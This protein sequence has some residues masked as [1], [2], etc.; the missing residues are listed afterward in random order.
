MVLYCHHWV[1]DCDH[2]VSPLPIGHVPVN[3]VWIRN[4]SYD[5]AQGP[6]LVLAGCSVPCTSPKTCFLVFFSPFLTRYT[7][8]PAMGRI[9]KSVFLS[10]RRT[11]APWALAIFQDLTHHG[12][13]VFYDFY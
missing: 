9:E 2:V 7:R 6:A 3:D 13:D 5:S 8:F 4:L 11:N 1:V 12:Y 10:Y